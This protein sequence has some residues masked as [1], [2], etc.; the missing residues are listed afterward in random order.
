MRIFLHTL[1]KLTIGSPLLGF[2]KCG[3]VDLMSKQLRKYKHSYLVMSRCPGKSIYVSNTQEN[4]SA[5]T[6]KIDNRFPAFRFSETFGLKLTSK[7]T[8]RSQNTYSLRAGCLCDEIQKLHVTAT[9]SQVLHG[10]SR[11]GSVLKAL[12]LARYLQNT[13]VWGSIRASYLVILGSR[14]VFSIFQ[15][16]IQIYMHD[17]GNNSVTQ[18]KTG[19]FM[20]GPPSFRCGPLHRSCKQLSLKSP[21]VAHS[22]SRWNFAENLEKVF[23]SEISR[24][25]FRGTFFTLEELPRPAQERILGS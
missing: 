10:V 15:C 8:C 5:H 22:R 4:I 2:S 23:S 14:R 3:F 6:Q 7:Q 21:L 11:D 13:I 17:W 9:H 12:L 18:R 25:L 20:N 1:K 19:A 24:Y 16:E